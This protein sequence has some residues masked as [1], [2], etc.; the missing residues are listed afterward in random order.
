LLTGA[1]TG[2][3]SLSVVSGTGIVDKQIVI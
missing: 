1:V 3:L 2:E